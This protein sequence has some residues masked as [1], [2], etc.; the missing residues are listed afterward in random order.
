VARGFR[1][2][3]GKLIFFSPPT[4]SAGMGLWVLFR[5]LAGTPDGGA[6][7][8]WKAG[9]RFY[10]QAFA[11]WGLLA[12]AIALGARGERGFRKEGSSRCAKVVRG[13]GWAPM[14]GS[15]LLRKGSIR[16]GPIG[17]KVESPQHA[18]LH[19]LRKGSS[20]ALGP[21]SARNGGLG[22]WGVAGEQ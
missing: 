19:L 7:S 22:C 15:Y 16:R 5:S 1:E 10:D 21:R 3:R 14:D 13:F 6:A 11:L 18:K 17:K 2:A 12:A 20:L 8:D 9:A 4:I